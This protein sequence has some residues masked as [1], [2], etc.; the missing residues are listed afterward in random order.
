MQA[1]AVKKMLRI[2]TL[3]AFVFILVGSGLCPSKLEQ[4]RSMS[5]SRDSRIVLEC[6]VSFGSTHFIIGLS[7]E[8]VAPRRVQNSFSDV[9]CTVNEAYF[10]PDD[11]LQ[12]KIIHFIDQ[13]K[14]GIYLAIF[15]FTNKAIADALV[16]AHERGVDIQ[17]VADP[18]F[19]HDRYTKI[20]LLQEKGISVFVYDPKKSSG[21]ASTMSNI[22]HNK[23][24]LFLN[25]V[26]DKPLI[27]TGSF[28]FTKSACLSNQENVV[29]LNHPQI[30]SRYIDKFHELKKRT[31]AYNRIHAAAGRATTK[32]NNKK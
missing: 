21:N 30:V 9:E 29:V 18:S 31:I 32:K 10:S 7:K 8:E 11:D 14:K 2:L 22:M 6:P 4:D 26:D 12:Q 19:L 5:E 23:F 28:N 17:L 15:S 13:E 25:N 3:F 1:R 27:W 20:S 24:M 16:C